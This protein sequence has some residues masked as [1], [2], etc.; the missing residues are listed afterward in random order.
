[1][2]F[3]QLSA[4]LEEQVPVLMEKTFGLP[5]YL[6]LFLS[7]C[8]NAQT[9][10]VSHMLMAQV[11]SF[12]LF[13]KQEIDRARAIAVI[14]LSSLNQPHWIPQ[15]VAVPE[16]WAWRKIDFSDRQRMRAIARKRRMAEGKERERPN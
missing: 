6:N 3:L 11:D 7:L 4:S 15:A 16:A 5:F 10:V 9:D 13:R 12:I 8:V 1:M 14:I 2:H